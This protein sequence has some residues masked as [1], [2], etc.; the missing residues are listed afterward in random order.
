MTRKCQNCLTDSFES[1]KLTLEVTHGGLKGLTTSWDSKHFPGGGGRKISHSDIISCSK[2][3]QKGG[4]GTS[5][6]RP[7]R[8]KY[9][10][11]EKTFELIGWKNKKPTTKTKGFLKFLCQLCDRRMTKKAPRNVIC[12][13]GLFYFIYF[14]LSVNQMPD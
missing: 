14:F 3:S 12:F 8:C 9:A 13:E 5:G 6:S 4:L 11:L 2:F 1:D 10:R 7:N